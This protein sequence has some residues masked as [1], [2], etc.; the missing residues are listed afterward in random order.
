MGG[1]NAQKSAMARARNLEKANADKVRL[2]EI[3]IW[4]RLTTTPFS[5]N[6]GGG[7]K[8]QVARSGVNMAEAMAAA[9]L[10]REE[11]K[12]KREEKEKKK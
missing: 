5:Q 7:L 4:L 9:N 1:G 12:K 3:H 10:K 2:W 11:V 6:S 8:G